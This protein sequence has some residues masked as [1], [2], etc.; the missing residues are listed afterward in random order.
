MRR[1]TSWTEDKLAKDKAGRGQLEIIVTQCISEAYKSNAVLV[2][3]TSNTS[4]CFLVKPLNMKD[5]NQS[6]ANSQTA[7]QRTRRAKDKA[8]RGQRWQGT[9]L[10]EDG[11]GTGQG[12]KRTRLEEGKRKEGKLNEDKLEEDRAG[13]GRGWRRTRLAEDK[14]GR[15]HAGRGHAGRGQ[16]GQG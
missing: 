3:H 13:E 12:W 5:Q 2:T 16:G 9:R 7:A 10:A 14:A 15:G 11:A 6:P 8:E 4:T 1:R